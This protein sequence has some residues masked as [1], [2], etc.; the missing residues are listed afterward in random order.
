MLESMD[1]GKAKNKSPT[2]KRGLKERNHKLGAC[3][4]TLRK[5]MKKES[6]NY[7]HLKASQSGTKVE[8]LSILRRAKEVSIEQRHS[9]CQKSTP[10]KLIFMSFSV[11]DKAS[12]VF[13]R[14]DWLFIKEKLDL[15][16]N[17]C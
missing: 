17:P 3:E 10:E 2:T 13:K 5:A 11:Y 16:Y 9:K 6:E 4:K 14:L 1:K 7:L 8:C 12:S 15:H